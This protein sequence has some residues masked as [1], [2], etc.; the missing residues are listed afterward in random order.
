MSCLVKPRNQNGSLGTQVHVAA[1]M[2]GPPKE[3][4]LSLKV[5]MNL[6]NIVCIEYIL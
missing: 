6:P 4:T 1:H 3:Q 5:F 2:H